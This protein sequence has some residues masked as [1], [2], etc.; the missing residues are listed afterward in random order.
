MTL[1]PSTRGNANSHLNKHVVH[2]QLKVSVCQCCQLKKKREEISNS[3]SLL[4]YNVVV[5]LSGCHENPCTHVWLYSPFPV[6]TIVP[7]NRDP[8]EGG[9]VLSNTLHDPRHCAAE[10][11]NSD[12]V[13]SL[14]SS[15]VQK[16][17]WTWIMNGVEMGIENCTYSM[18]AYNYTVGVQIG[19]SNRG[20]DK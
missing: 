5:A 10:G 18:W 9:C 6:C 20:G 11:D 2:N 3:V 16:L 15:S 12:D 1:G 4:L 13:A 14:S 19:H 7:E 17:F 8:R